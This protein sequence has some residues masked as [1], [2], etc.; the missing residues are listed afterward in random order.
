MTN[1]IS[2]NVEAAIN[3]LVHLSRPQI[4]PAAIVSVESR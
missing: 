2:E 1:A 3:W 4:F